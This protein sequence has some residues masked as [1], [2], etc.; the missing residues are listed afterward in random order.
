MVA[1][2]RKV[3][4]TKSRSPEILIIPEI[5]EQSPNKALRQFCGG[6]EI[7]RSFSQ[8]QRIRNPK[9][10][11]RGLVFWKECTQH[12]WTA[13]IYHKNQKNRIG[14]FRT[15]EAAARAYDKA[16]TILYGDDAV[17]NFPKEQ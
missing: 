16:A 10:G 15:K 8:H 11:Y 5:P 9:Y 12:P 14:R 6:Y 7:D 3:G 4:I 2:T 13:E 17:L 1:G